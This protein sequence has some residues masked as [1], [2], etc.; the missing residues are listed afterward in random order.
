VI[1]SINHDGRGRDPGAGVLLSSTQVGGLCS[2]HTAT[3]PLTLATHKSANTIVDALA[4]EEIH[5]GTEMLFAAAKCKNEQ[6]IYPLLCA[7]SCKKETAEDM[8]AIFEL[9]MKDWKDSGAE[10][11]VGEIWDFATDSDK[12]RRKAGY[13]IF[14]QI[15]LKSSTIFI[16]LSNLPGLNL[17]TG[18]GLILIMFDWHHI[19]KRE[20]HSFASYPH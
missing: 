9:I 20:F 2:K 14:V 6:L 15:E 19:L 5:F 16:T 11:E 17:F 8:V 4:N 7:L 13:A 10:A 3:T 1:W 12:L 18:P